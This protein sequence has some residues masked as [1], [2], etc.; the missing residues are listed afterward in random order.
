MTESS[1]STKT[2]AM[3]REIRVVVKVLEN[4][5]CVGSKFFKTIF[6]LSDMLQYGHKKDRNM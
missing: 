1:I 4:G 5:A 6:W 2:G 3:P